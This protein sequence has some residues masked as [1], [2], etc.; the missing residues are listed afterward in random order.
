MNAISFTPHLVVNATLGHW[1]RR[2]ERIV[3]V[4]TDLARHND[5]LLDLSGVHFNVTSFA[6]A[7]TL[8]A[9][10]PVAPYMIGS[11]INLDGGGGG[12][13]HT[14][15]RLLNTSFDA[16]KLEAAVFVVVGVAIAFLLTASLFFAA[17][18]CIYRYTVPIQP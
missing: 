12:D 3:R 14:N 13:D 2:E 5:T 8:M 4:L 10:K 9:P 11:G 1:S 17:C 7:E 6:T 16:G 18:Q 15:L